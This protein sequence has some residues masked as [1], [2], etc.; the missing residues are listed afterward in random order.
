MERWEEETKDRFIAA[1]KAMGHGEWTVSGCEVIVDVVTGRNFDYE[2]RSGTKQ[3]IALEIF[4]LLDSGEEVARQ[5]LWARVA[6]SI[7]S[8]LRKRGTRGYSIPVAIRDAPDF[9]HSALTHCLNFSV[10][11]GWVP[12]RTWIS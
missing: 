4:R 2:L 5:K 12:W 8:E 10:W 9:R 3:G 6:N 11:A 7:A 1:L